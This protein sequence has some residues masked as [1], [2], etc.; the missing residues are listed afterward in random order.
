MADVKAY[1]IKVSNW[2]SS[3]DATITGTTYTV[4]A[5]SRVF[6]VSSLNWVDE[7]NKPTIPLNKKVGEFLELKNIVRKKGDVMDELLPKCD[8]DWD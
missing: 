4:R 5:S 7:D 6:T 8:I 1:I 3:K 2:T